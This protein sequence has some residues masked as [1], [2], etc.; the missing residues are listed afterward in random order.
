MDISHSS[1]Y[2]THLTYEFCVLAIYPE[3]GKRYIYRRERKSQISKSKTL[4]EE[5]DN[6]QR[7]IIMTV[8]MIIMMVMMVMMRVMAKY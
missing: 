6:V 8:M 1:L 3:L 5:T 4:L 7:K 2:G